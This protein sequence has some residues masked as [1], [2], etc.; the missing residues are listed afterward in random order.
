MVYGSHTYNRY[1]DRPNGRSEQACQQ[2]FLHAV[3]D[4][5]YKENRAQRPVYA[6][7]SLF[8]M[9]CRV[10]ANTAMLTPMIQPPYSLDYYVSRDTLTVKSIVLLKL[11]DS[12]DA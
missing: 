11:F 12:P 7:C 4:T 1:S 9:V 8:Q 2:Q 3:K 6:Q 5:H 10:L